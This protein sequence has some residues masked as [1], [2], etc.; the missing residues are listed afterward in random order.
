V[1]PVKLDEAAMPTTIADK[2]YADFSRSYEE[3]FEK[4]IRS[5]KARKVTRD[6]HN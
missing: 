6:D 2:L 1:F 4:L 5:I 3:G